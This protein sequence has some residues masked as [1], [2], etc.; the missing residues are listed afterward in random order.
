MMARGPEKRALLWM[1]RSYEQPGR[2]WETGT[3]WCA[4]HANRVMGD[5]QERRGTQGQ[6]K[7]M[8]L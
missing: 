4:S 6:G 7:H 8:F 3:G 5:Q 1:I 2:E